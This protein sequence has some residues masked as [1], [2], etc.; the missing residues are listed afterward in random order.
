MAMKLLAFHNEL[1]A[2]LPSDEQD[3]HF[4]SLD[5]IQGTQIAYAQLEFRE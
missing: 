3:Y 4:I 1:V 5:I 2:V